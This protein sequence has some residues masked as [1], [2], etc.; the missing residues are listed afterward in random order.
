M[1]DLT[2]NN[3]Y[4]IYMYLIELL[5]DLATLGYQ[6]GYQDDAAHICVYIVSDLNHA[7][8]FIMYVISGQQFRRQFID[9]IYCKSW[10]SNTSSNSERSDSKN[11]SNG[12]LLI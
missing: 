1:R 9:I 8:N 2:T 3:L 11:H 12:L 5:L 6:P 4:L 7:I 10:R